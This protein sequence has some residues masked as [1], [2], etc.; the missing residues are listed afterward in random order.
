MMQI[1]CYALLIVPQGI[2]TSCGY[3]NHGLIIDL[4]I[5]PQGIE[6]MN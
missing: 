2:E 3:G 5:V 6:T 4:L 1:L